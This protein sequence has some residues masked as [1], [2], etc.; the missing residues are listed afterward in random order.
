M[1]TFVFV[2]VSIER[3]QDVRFEAVH[4]DRGARE[5]ADTPAAPA[6]NWRPW[7]WFRV[8]SASVREQRRL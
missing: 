4:R 3:R 6:K 2:E 7:A 8:V 1:L 5:N